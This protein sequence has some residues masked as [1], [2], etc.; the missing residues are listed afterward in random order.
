MNDIEDLVQFPLTP[1][2]T[3]GGMK[4]HHGGRG[5]SKSE[6]ASCGDTHGVGINAARVLPDWLPPMLRR[7]FDCK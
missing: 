7:E 6:G 5:G 2:R 4:G 3:V 1:Q